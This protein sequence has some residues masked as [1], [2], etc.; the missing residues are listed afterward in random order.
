[1][2]NV[3]VVNLADNINA[4]VL[5]INQNFAG[6][7]AG[8]IGGG[9]DSSEVVGVITETVDSD[10]VNNLVDIP[11]A[12]VD[13]SVVNNIVNNILD[14]DYF[15]T[16]I[17]QDY[18]NQFTINTDVSYLDSDISA[19]ASAI[20]QLT[21]RIDATDSGVLVL[22]QALTQTQADLDGLVLDGFDSDA[23]VSAVTSANSQVI[24]RIEATESDL[25]IFSGVL[26]SVEAQLIIIDS[27]LGVRI[28][29]EANARSQLSSTVTAQGGTITTLSQDVTALDNAV[30]IRDSDGNIT[31]TAL[32][33]A[34]NA[35]TNQITQVDGRI[36]TV[37]AGLTTDLQAY[38]DGVGASVTNTLEAY[39]DAAT[40]NTTASW[41]LDL[42]AGDTNNPYVAGIKFGNDGAS[43]DFVLSADTFQL[44]TPT[45]SD[46]TGGISP[47]TVTANGVELSN[48]KVTGAI[49]VTTS[50]GT[51]SMNIKGELITISDGNGT[52]RIKLG[53]LSA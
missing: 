52:P 53:D 3:Q 2:S 31:S 33:S 42:T 21:S 26:D 10:Y 39:V 37:E 50:S 51:G 22:S 5:K 44:V 23:L 30:F 19:N 16:V 40:G 34:E 12:G 7:D 32:A 25:T 48:A 4:A 17:N 8:D 38:A 35:L 41:N 14:S 15:I 28:D 1:M 45:D 43:A 18:L 13:S 9:L 47:F 36:T 27:D 24:S 6:V 20:F 11:D 49:D 46:G 29:A